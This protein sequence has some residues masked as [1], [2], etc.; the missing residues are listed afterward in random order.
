[1]LY[2]DF[3]SFA[4]HEAWALYERE[5]SERAADFDPRVL[6]RIEEHAERRAKDYIRLHLARNELRHRF[7]SE[8]AGVDVI[9]APTLPVLPPRLDQLVEDESYFRFN[10]LM[11][12]NTAPFNA[13]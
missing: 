1:A 13:L 5:L 4:S 10:G 2:R 7:W 11:L 12:R 8:L 3:G 6:H 9:V